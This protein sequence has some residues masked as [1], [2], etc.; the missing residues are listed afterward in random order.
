MDPETLAALQEAA[1]R[2]GEAVAARADRP[3][4]RRSAPEQGASS[5]V[6]APVSRVQLAAADTQGL[7]HFSGYAS[8]TERG[9][10]MWD[11][12][13]PYTEVISAGAFAGTLA[14]EDLDVPLVLQHSSLRRI[15]RTTTG[16]LTLLED[17]TGLLVDAPALDAADH[18]VAY[19]A[20]KLRAGL[21]DE[22]SFM[23]RILRGQWSPDYT[24]YRITEVDLHRGDVA[25]V[26]YG[27]NP[28]T[29]G[30]LRSADALEVV[31]SLDEPTAREAL[32]MLRSRLEPS[33]SGA[34]RGRDVVT[35]HD[36][37]LLELV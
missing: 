25:I 26:G 5:R 32:T 24:E 28:Y 10:D 4:H 31:R 27:A 9:Y 30:A 1:T 18:D 33:G 23:F 14:R 37:R 16:T 22:M 6:V 36:T 35:S 20:P 7:L 3:S 29:S 11:W 12:Y 15:A 21:I 2:R 8:V 34:R 19:I 13:G 17:E